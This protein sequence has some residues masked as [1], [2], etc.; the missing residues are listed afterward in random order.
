MLTFD[1]IKKL[2][3]LTVDIVVKEY[4]ENKKNFSEWKIDGNTFLD[5]DTIADCY[6]ESLNSMNIE[7]KNDVY[8]HM[9]YRYVCNEVRQILFVTGYTNK[10][11]QQDGDCVL[12]R[13]SMTYEEYKTWSLKR[14]SISA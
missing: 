13:D 9:T 6:A 3:W 1:E 14:S 5:S 11:E 8:E 4:E 12:Q 10:L 7:K 2:V